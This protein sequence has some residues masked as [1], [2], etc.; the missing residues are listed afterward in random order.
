MLKD[1]NNRFKGCAIISFKDPEM[2]EEAIQTMNRK[3]FKGR[4]LVVKEEDA[5]PDL[6]SGGDRKRMREDFDRVSLPITTPV[7]TNTANYNTYGLSLTFLNSLNI[8]LPLISIV[9][10]NLDYTVSESDLRD[11]F[12]LAGKIMDIE[13]FKDKE[14]KSRGFGVVEYEHPVE[15][16]QAISMLHNQ[17][18]RDRLLTVRM[19]RSDRKR[20]SKPR[21]PPGLKSVG[22]GLG[23]DGKPLKDIKCEFSN[24]DVQSLPAANPVSGINTINPINQVNSVLGSM[25]TSLTNQI[26]PGVGG[27][28]DPLTSRM[29]VNP[30]GSLTGGLNAPGVGMN[31]GR[32]FS[33]SSSYRGGTLGNIIQVSNKCLTDNHLKEE[34]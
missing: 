11:V 22:M 12:C 1:E 17:S 24:K 3:E 2:A 19:D 5:I 20:D 15:A 33:Q 29:N 13:I 8:E 34:C 21:L 18:Y 27:L 30:T 26:A 6:K 14:G 31:M 16:V 32:D 28:M 10:A 25:N 4:K 23:V 7:A 9:L